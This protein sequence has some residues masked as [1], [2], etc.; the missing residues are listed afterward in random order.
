V[1]LEP[2]V[3]EILDEYDVPTPRHALATSPQEASVAGGRIGYPVAMKVVSPE[4]IHKS[5]AGCV[6]LNVSRE[7]V[8]C[9]YEEIVA[10]ARTHNPKA[11]L[12]GVMVY[13]MMPKGLEMAVG[14][15]RKPP[16]GPF[17][18]VGLGGVFVEALRDIQFVMI[19]ASSKDVREK[20]ERLK[21]YPILKGFRGMRRVDIDAVTSL[22]ERVSQL[23][24]ENPE[25]SQIDLNPVIAY[26][27]RA[28][29]VDAR[30]MLEKTNIAAVNA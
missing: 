8:A 7:E 2:D 21:A 20:L 14:M 18:M 13:E 17:L 11:D 23:A 10:N 9:A 4:I 19:P 15:V 6:K 27:N 12:K 1:L 25:I 30:M 26:E 24:V 3:M 22:A 16:F 29:A 5:D 28:V